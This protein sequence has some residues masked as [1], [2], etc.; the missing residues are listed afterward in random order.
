MTSSRSSQIMQ[1]HQERRHGDGKADA[2]ALQQEGQDPRHD[3]PPD[4]APSELVISRTKSSTRRRIQFA[5][6]RQGA[7][8]RGRKT[9]KA[10]TPPCISISTRSDHRQN[11]SYRPGR[12]SGRS[13]HA[14]TSISGYSSTLLKTSGATSARAGRRRRRRPTSRGN[15][16][17]GACSP[18]GRRPSPR[19]IPAP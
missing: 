18:G 3:D 13:R 10:K 12:G 15:T 16:R 7:R 8:A 9:A 2:A 6:R 17:S 1:T 4:L 11:R 5:A 14:A 19:G